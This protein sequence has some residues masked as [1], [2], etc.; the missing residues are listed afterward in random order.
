MT[1]LLLLKILNVLA[2][3]LIMHVTTSYYFNIFRFE[4]KKWWNLDS[5]K[6]SPKIWRH[7][8][9]D[10]V[11]VSIKLCLDFGNDDYV[12]LCNFWCRIMS[13]FDVIDG[14]SE[15]PPLVAGHKKKIPGSI[16]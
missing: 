8:T 3:F 1:S 4:E 5:A 6:K 15:A 11:I 13:G 12:I 7:N 14:A 9:S 10:Y 2:N 16:K